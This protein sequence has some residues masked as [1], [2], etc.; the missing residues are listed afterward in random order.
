MAGYQDLRELER[1]VIAGARKMGHSISAMKFGFS[2]M[3]ISLVYREY[4]ESNFNTG[5][6]TSVTVRTMQRKI[7][8]MGF[9]S[10]SPTGVPLLTARHKA[11]RLAWARQHR[12]WTVDNWKCIA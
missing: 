9:W 7:I 5:P 6:S 2:L 1:G 8:D 4:W 3:A 11:L 12:H 10:R